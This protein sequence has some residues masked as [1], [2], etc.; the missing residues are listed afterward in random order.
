MRPISWKKK[1]SKGEVYDCCVKVIDEQKLIYFIDCTCWN[2]KNRRIKHKGC[3]SDKK[4]YA[5]PCKHLEPV[6]DALI[7]Q[8]YVLKEPKEMEGTD[9]CTPELKKFILE[10]SIGKCEYCFNRPVTEI[11]RKIPRTNGGKYNKW[12]CVGICDWCH[13]NVTYQPWRDSPSTIGN[14]K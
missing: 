1:G 10:R 11:H 8:G 6:V 7:K 4:F 5:E 2:F 9:Y 13:E 14:T 3:F 12:N